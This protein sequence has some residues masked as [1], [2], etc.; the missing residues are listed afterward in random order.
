MPVY[1]S[2]KKNLVT[3]NLISNVAFPAYDCFLAQYL[4]PGNQLLT[5]KTFFVIRNGVSVAE[6]C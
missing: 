2:L 1:D 4:I 6:P 5:R 3:G